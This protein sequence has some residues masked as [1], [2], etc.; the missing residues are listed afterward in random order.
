MLPRSIK[1]P[2]KIKSDVKSFQLEGTV[3]YLH[4]ETLNA[5]RAEEI[6]KLSPYL[7]VSMELMDVYGLLEETFKALSN[8]TVLGDVI[9]IT[10]KIGNVLK[11]TRDKTAGDMVEEQI[12][13]VFDI[14]CMCML[15]EGEDATKIDRALQKR[16]KQMMKRSGDFISFFLIARQLSLMFKRS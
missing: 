13:V 16:K 10:N 1:T 11:V 9:N 8:I 7:S 15:I 6:I 3:F 4:Q 2:D 14:C 12:E 5:L